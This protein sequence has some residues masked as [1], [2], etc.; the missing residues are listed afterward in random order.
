MLE[1]SVAALQARRCGP[2]G[3]SWRCRRGRLDALP[4]GVV[5]VAGGATRSQSV[6]EA[7]QACGDGDPVI[8]HDAARPLATADLFERALLELEP[9]RTP[10]R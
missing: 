5:T 3:S 6:R 7:L 4:E 8:V 10:T 9:A 2:S 1:W